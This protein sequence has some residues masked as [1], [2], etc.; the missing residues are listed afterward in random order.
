MVREPVSLYHANILLSCMYYTAWTG[1][2]QYLNPW[3]IIGIFKKIIN[4]IGPLE[5]HYHYFNLESRV[6]YMRNLKTQHVEKKCGEKPK[7]KTKEK[8]HLCG[9]DINMANM[10]EKNSKETIN[11]MLHPSMIYY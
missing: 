2:Q 5:L 7:P 10:S 6:Y 3:C 8:C 1:L 9:G 4:L 11:I